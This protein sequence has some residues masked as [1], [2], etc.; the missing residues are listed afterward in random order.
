MPLGGGKMKEYKIMKSWADYEKEWED[1]E[2]E[3]SRAIK[4]LEKMWGE[5]NDKAVCVESTG[6][7]DNQK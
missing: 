5:R 1:F 2:Q 4:E 6:N 3:F 7:R